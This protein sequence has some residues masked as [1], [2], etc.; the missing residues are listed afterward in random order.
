MGRG[1]THRRCVRARL[2]PGAPGAPC[3]RVRRLSAA[4]AA[5]TLRLRINRR[6]APAA[7]RG[8]VPPPA[9]ADPAS[10]QPELGATR[11][12]LALTPA[13]PSGRSAPCGTPRR[14]A[15]P[16]QPRRFTWFGLRRR[17]GL[18]RRGA[19][20]T[21]RL[22]LGSPGTA[23]SPLCL[24]RR[25]L[26]RGRLPRGRR[27]GPGLRAARVAAALRP[28]VP[29]DVLDEEGGEWLGLSGRLRF[30]GPQLGSPEH[31]G[32]SAPAPSLG[33][34]A[35]APAAAAP[36]SLSAARARLYPWGRAPR[37]V[38]I[39]RGDPG[40]P[41]DWPLGA[42]G[43]GGGKGEHFAPSRSPLP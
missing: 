3:G 19:G 16:P 33:T 39:G 35:V 28:A 23:S 8:A 43:E 42:P 34:L 18:H 21:T 14:T 10:R 36:L 4:C 2:E 13:Q 7:G 41:A 12:G 5:L 9:A 40:G 11:L 1:R 24:R 29:Q 31:P 25:G 37:S 32:D 30:P 38:P 6:D 27:R 26:P 22:V 20:P 15:R 17:L